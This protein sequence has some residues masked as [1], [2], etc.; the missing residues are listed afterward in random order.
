MRILLSSYSFGAN[1]GSEAG[2]GWNVAKGLAQR[3]HEITVLTTTE[4]HAVNEPAV[5]ESGL[6]VRLVEWD[7]GL[8]A[9]EFPLAFSYRR[10]QQAAGARLRQLCAETSF[11]IVHHVTF[12][13]YRG[14][15]DVFASGLPY[16]VGPVGGAETVPRCLLGDLPLGRRIK[17][18]VRRLPWDALPLGR[19]VRSAAAPGMILASTPGTQRRLQ[20]TA[21]IAGVRLMPVIAI[22]GEEI[23]VEPPTSSADPFFV[24]YGGGARAEK[25]TLLL[26]RCMARLWKQGVH[27]PVR[28]VA[29]QESLRPGLQRYAASQG[30]PSGAVEFPPFM[31]RS[32]LLALMRRSAA[33]VALNF[34]DDGCMALLEAVAQ[35]VPSVCLDIPSQF[36][37]PQEFALKVPVRAGEVEASLARALDKALHS[38]PADAAWHR[39]RVSFL[40]EK[41]LWPVRI[42]QL[43]Q[44]YNELLTHF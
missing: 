2:V 22:A 38:P 42:G 34:R 3:G 5:R 23:A 39:R 17:E 9:A 35:G 44:C 18:M 12:N 4:F 21:G 27:V 36:W 10:W 41:M 13:Q 19:R 14:V 28:L 11:D 43:E 30:L 32:E 20:R 37:L 16:V 15:K 40:R 29:V 24:F 7:A 33:F 25:G 26:L 6:P 31:P 8:S 1:R